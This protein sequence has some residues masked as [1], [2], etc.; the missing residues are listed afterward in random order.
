[1]SKPRTRLTNVRDY[2]VY[3]V[4]RI[5]G[6]VVQA[7]S[8]ERACNL[9]AGLAWLAYHVDRRHRLVAIENLRHAFPGQYT[10]AELER[11]VRA[12]YRHF[13]TL[14][15]ELVHLPRRLHP[16]TWRRHLDLD[17]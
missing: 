4:I 16:N 1:M 3:L 10:E 7:L 14:L 8:F 17:G 15:V 9:A 12:V 11:L 6:C 2:L 13:C 5:A